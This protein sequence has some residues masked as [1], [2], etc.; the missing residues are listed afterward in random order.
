MVQ[1]KVAVREAHGPSL[2]DEATVIVLHLTGLGHA[3]QRMDPAGVAAGARQR[4]SSALR[5][6][7]PTR[8]FIRP[9]PPP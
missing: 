6:S 7:L 9:R 4:P 3:G 1:I 5:W 8:P 2:E